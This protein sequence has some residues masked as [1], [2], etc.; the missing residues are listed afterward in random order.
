MNLKFI[1]ALPERVWLFL[2]SKLHAFYVQVP[3]SCNFYNICS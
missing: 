3:N 1:A 2:Y